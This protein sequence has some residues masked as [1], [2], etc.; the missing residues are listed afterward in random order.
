MNQ[1]KNELPQ[2]KPFL[3]SKI[4]EKFEICLAVIAITYSLIQSKF[5]FVEFKIDLI[6]NS[7]LI[8]FGFII[9]YYREDYWG[10]GREQRMLYFM[11]NSFG[12]IRFPSK[13]KTYFDNEELSPGLLKA[14]ANVH[15]NTFFTS[16]ISEKMLLIPI[17]IMLFSA[18]IFII[19]LMIGG[20]NSGNAALLNLYL[21]GNIATKIINIYKLKKGTE[22][23]FQSGNIIC[24][25]Y[26]ECSNN[27]SELEYDMILLIN[28]YENL[29]IDTKVTL[30]ERV[31]S[32][33]NDSLTDDWNEHKKHYQIYSDNSNVK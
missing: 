31:F 27:I 17:G 15:E 10:I 3:I 18:F 22:E 32:R 25:R 24:S 9:S 14:F 2:A 19:S 7:M 5:N 4:F 30:S 29:L 20:L 8:F 6:I 28:N 21:S 12:T 16:K 26:Q 1:Q 33:M 13:N 23:L 11:D